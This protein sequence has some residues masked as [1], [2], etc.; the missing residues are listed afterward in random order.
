MNCCGLRRSYSSCSSCEC[1]TDFTTS[2]IIYR[3]NMICSILKEESLCH[4]F[5]ILY[6][7]TAMAMSWVWFPD[8]LIK[9]KTWMQCKMLW[10]EAN[11]WMFSNIISVICLVSAESRTSVSC[12]MWSSFF[13]WC[14]THTCSRWGW[15]RCYWSDS[16]RCWYCLH[17]TWL[18]ASAFTAG[19]WC[20]HA[21]THTCTHTYMHTH[22]H[23]CTHT[24]TRARTHAHTHWLLLAPT[25]NLWRQKVICKVI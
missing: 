1:I 16:E 6:R 9:C 2:H 19:S 7:H 17:S 23:T 11:A 25:W 14:S 8:E 18:S 15:C 13:S 5:K 24:H 3:I 22:T 21:R 12:L 4:I 10:I 20:V